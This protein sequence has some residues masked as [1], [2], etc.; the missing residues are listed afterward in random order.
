M[1]KDVTSRQHSIHRPYGLRN[2][3]ESYLRCFVPVTTDC[4]DRGICIVRNA[5]NPSP[6]GSEKTTELTKDHKYHS[7]VLII[8]TKP[9]A[10]GSPTT[11]SVSKKH[12]CD[13]KACMGRGSVAGIEESGK[14]ERRVERAGLLALG[15]A[16]PAR[17]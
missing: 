14:V 8:I 13:R 2:S 12:H 5:P 16:R 10:C 4:D 11:Y 6:T 1:A 17:A 9:N 3:T 15:L 7:S